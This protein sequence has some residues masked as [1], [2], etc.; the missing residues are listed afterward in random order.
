MNLAV[1]VSAHDKH[2]LPEFTK[3]LK[4]FGGLEDTPVTFF[5]TPAS[6][7]ETY[8]VSDLL[9]ARVHVFNADFPD[10]WPTAPGM[11]FAATV[12][13]LPTLGLHGPWLWMELDVLPVKQGWLQALRKAYTLG[14][15]PFMGNV[16]PTAW[17]EEGKLVIHENDKMMM[18]CGVYP[19]GMHGD[20]RFK[21][22]LTDL[23]KP[24]SL[25]PRTPFDF[26][27][28]FAIRQT[29][30]IDTPLIADM[31]QTCNYRQTD[32][33]LACDPVKLDKPRR[34]RGGLIS[35][36][37]VIVHGCKDGSLAKILLSGTAVKPKA[38]TPALTVA[39]PVTPPAPV[40]A[41][42]P[43]PAPAPVQ[44]PAP[45]MNPASTSKLVTRADV[46]AVLKP[47]G[48]FTKRVAKALGLSMAEFV[49]QFP[50]L[51]YRAIKNG[52]MESTL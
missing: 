45:V 18:G 32:A 21:P 46:E 29:G 26:Y 44:K 17:T 47:N 40:A 3:V 31:W 22:L 27:L 48:G 43:A 34:E 23:L 51:G 24:G 30:V 19:P 4:H 36:E 20:Q 13:T 35:S 7:A 39:A 14:G 38:A 37:A 1:P 25:N 16:V 52:R 33:G 42:V 9:N 6:K 10:G 2:L 50:T 11:Q 28:R 5:C 8:E 49:S 12:F 15:Q 41:P